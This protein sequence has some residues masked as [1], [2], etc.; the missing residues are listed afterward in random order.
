MNL[1]AS[2]AQATEEQ[3]LLR[4][5]RKRQSP[6]ERQLDINPLRPKASKN[7]KIDW[8]TGKE[9]RYALEIAQNL[10]KRVLVQFGGRDQ[11]STRLAQFTYR[12]REVVD[13]AKRFV[14]IF[15]PFK[16]GS[17]AVDKY[18]IAGS[19][20]CH[21]LDNDGTEITRQTGFIKPT[22][23]AAFLKSGQR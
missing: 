14:C 7:Q 13:L 19:P 12:D 21:V 18:N 22:V 1:E 5:Y 4:M 8:L 15:V 11:G 16:K 10:D 3:F 17:D 2:P 6:L 23:F 9:I 20:T